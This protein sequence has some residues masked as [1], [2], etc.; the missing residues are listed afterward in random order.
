MYKMNDN[1]NTNENAC[2]SDVQMS[3]RNNPTDE[4]TT[5]TVAQKARVERNRQAALLL[6]QARLIPHPYAKM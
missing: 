1:S 6:K 4:N 2:A 3:N 5:L